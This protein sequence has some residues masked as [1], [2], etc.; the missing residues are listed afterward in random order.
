VRRAGAGEGSAGR[1][2]HR[3]GQ[4]R[5]RALRGAPRARARADHHVH[6]PDQ[7]AVQPEVRRAAG[8]ARGGERRAPHGGRLRQ[9]PR[10][11]DR[12]DHRGAAQHAVQRLP[13]PGG[14]RRGGH[15]RGPLPRR[16]LP[17][18]CLGGGDHPPARPGAG[19]LP[20]R[21]RVQRRG[22]RAVAHDGARGHRGGGLGAPAGAALAARHGRRAALRSLQPERPR[23]RT[24]QSGASRRGAAGHPDARPAPPLPHPPARRGRGAGSRR[25]AARHLL[26]LLPRGL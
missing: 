2:T 25:A 19:H 14:P 12:D 3:S 26:H 22:V 4:D 9:S 8:P 11:G 24:A 17:R 6:D 7:G 15:G 20:V 21:H 13:V 18:S 1:R 16:P 10:T 23:G 5:G